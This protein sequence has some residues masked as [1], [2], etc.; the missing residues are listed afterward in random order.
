[1]GV[2]TVEAEA[3]SLAEILGSPIERREDLPLIT[4][5]AEYTDDIQHARTAHMAVV[6][7]RHAHARIEDMDTSAATAMDGVEAVYTAADIE[8][9]DAPA[10]LTVWVVE[11]Y[12]TFPDRPLLASDRVRY[13]GEPIAVVVADDRYVA[14]EAADAV[15]VTYE[16]LEAVTDPDEALAAEAPTIHEESPDNIALT[17][18]QG[19]AEETETAIDN[20]DHVIDLDLHNNRLI[21]T[22]ME[23]RA[24]I[25]RYRDSTGELTV[26]MTSQNPHLHQQWLA[27]TLGLPDHKIRVRAPHV[28]GGFGSKIHHY[29]DEALTAWC[30]MRM[31]RPVKWVATRSEGFLSTSH[32]RNHRST[33]RLGVDE[34][35]SI[36]GLQ[37]DTRVGV[38]G[39]LSSAEASVA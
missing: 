3:V 21:P 27:E 26:E 35:G 11:D 18:E 15:E 29:P 31:D 13:Q 32:G 4:G 37:V 17:W 9:S 38:G 8:A 39:F 33:V 30:A 12:A 16:R 20:A 24:A 10:R 36:R 6:R 28:G 7:S 14:A 25:A 19:D 23:P 22:A 5:D 34:D 1:M 2:R